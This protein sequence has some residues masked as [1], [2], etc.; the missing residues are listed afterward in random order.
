MYIVHL[1][2]VYLCVQVY[3]SIYL[4]IIL[5]KRTNEKKIERRVQ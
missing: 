2:F 4:Q 5:D 3:A 1:H